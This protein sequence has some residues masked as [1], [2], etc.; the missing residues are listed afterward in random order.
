MIQTTL[1]N[2]QILFNKAL[3]LNY[4]FTWVRGPDQ[5]WFIAEVLVKLINEYL[6]ANIPEIGNID[7]YNPVFEPAEKWIVK[8]LHELF[9]T[10]QSGVV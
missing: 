7:S 8:Q 10:T 1:G 4:L 3:S 6:K 9:L 2:K 5:E